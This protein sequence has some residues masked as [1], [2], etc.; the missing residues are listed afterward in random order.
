[1]DKAAIQGKSTGMQ[2]TNLFL[3]SLLLMHNLCTLVPRGKD[4]LFIKIQFKN[5]SL[6]N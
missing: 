3:G 2:R 6:A 5:S 1:M 4:I